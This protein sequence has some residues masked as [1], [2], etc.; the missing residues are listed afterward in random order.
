MWKAFLKDKEKVWKFW[1][2]ISIVRWLTDLREISKYVPFCGD[3]YF[4]VVPS[5]EF[6]GLSK[7]GLITENRSG[8]FKDE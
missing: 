8:S 6:F 2:D 4:L 7:F 3:N 1:L 5:H